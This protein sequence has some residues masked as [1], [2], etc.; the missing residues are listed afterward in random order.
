MNASQTTFSSG[1]TTAPQAHPIFNGK[2]EI[3][4]SLGEGNTSKVYLGRLIGGNDQYAAIK[5][6]KE[7]FLNRDQDS[8]VSVHNE[9][10]ILKNL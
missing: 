9:I 5:I 1:N 4:K 8:I 2:F 6:L 3:L 7:E 10:T